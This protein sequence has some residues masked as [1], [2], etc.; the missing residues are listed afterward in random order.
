MA[1]DERGSDED[2]LERVARGD[3]DGPGGLRMATTS[4]KEPM[5]TSDPQQPTPVEVL[6]EDRDAV[7]AFHK[8]SIDCLLNTTDADIDAGVNRAHG[9]LC[10]AFARHRIAA[11]RLP[12]GDD[13]ERE[14]ETG[15]LIEENT[16][17]HIH[18]IALAEDQWPLLKVSTRRSRRDS[19][20]DV[21]TQR[22]LTPVKRVKDAN[23][24]L[25]F[26]RKEDAE[27]MIR[28]FARFLLRPEATEHH[29]PARAALA[30]MPTPDQLLAQADIEE[31]L[32][33]E[34]A[35]MLPPGHHDA[36]A[37][38]RLGDA[39]ARVAALRRAAE[40]AFIVPP[41]LKL[42]PQ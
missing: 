41:R 32:A 27:A 2:F 42:G 1:D 15:W 29:W 20:Y 22:Y 40:G 39:R 30:A 17:G 4:P 10:E 13:V 25:R 37:V 12:A 23:A 34:L 7:A 14:E 6:Q 8:A 19:D 36:D 9:L 18:W 35:R 31:A 38:R 5:M 3:H 28:L 11:T 21:E 24:A 16:S 26:S 33:D